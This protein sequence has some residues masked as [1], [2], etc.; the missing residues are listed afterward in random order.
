MRVNKLRIKLNSWTTDIY[1]YIY[2]IL[3]ELLPCTY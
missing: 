3:C 1:I 2:E